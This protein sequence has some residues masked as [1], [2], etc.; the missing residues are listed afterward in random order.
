[1]EDGRAN[2]EAKWRL[3][4]M[5]PWDQ[6]SE[7]YLHSIYSLVSVTLTPLN[8]IP[9]RVTAPM[10][11][12]RSP[13]SERDFEPTISC[14]GADA[15]KLRSHH[16]GLAMRLLVGVLTSGCLDSELGLLPQ[17]TNILEAKD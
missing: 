14:M 8:L 3:S 4:L 16:Q 10:W 6:G 7:V 5:H 15:L 9:I 2:E 1:M 12:H 11:G 13:D 17:N